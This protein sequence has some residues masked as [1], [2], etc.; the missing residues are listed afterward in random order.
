MGTALGRKIQTI[1][2]R[3]RNKKRFAHPAAQFSVGQNE[4]RKRVAPAGEL[5][6]IFYAHEG[7]I[8]HKWHHYLEIYE[9]HF[10]PLRQR[11]EP[12]RILELGVS[13][14]GSLEI[15]RKYFG[16]EARIVGID[17]DP[18]CAE[19][20]DPD[21][22]IL[23][24]DQS[25]PALLATA[26]ERLGG[27]VDL[28]IDDGSHIGHHQTASFEYLYPRIS[29]RGVYVCEDL[30]CSYWPDYEGGYRRTGTFVE[31]TKDL[32]DRLQGWFLEEELQAQFM[33]FART[34]YGIFLY[35]DVLVIEKRPI[36]RPFHLQI[37]K[38]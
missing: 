2:D 20:A 4:A 36:E 27:G 1:I 5:Q 21:V 8:A 12:L 38:W 6:A 14:G 11:P 26:L 34:T 33:D 3:V 32:L 15:W 13:F 7:R 18:A 31:F 22:D 17:I 25:D 23:I 28:V 29:E 16:P 35:A 9:R 19:R 37:G 30:H 24:G 10:E